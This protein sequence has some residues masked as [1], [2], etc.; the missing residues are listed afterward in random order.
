M[1]GMLLGQ[2]RITEKIGAGAQP[3]N[4]VTICHIGA[5]EVK[6]GDDIHIG[7]VSRQGGPMEM[8]TEGFGQNGPPLPASGYVR[9]A[10]WSPRS[11]WMVSS[12]ASARRASGPRPR[13]SSYR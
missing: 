9:Y 8:L 11:R 2:Y 10:V 4:I 1:I 12:A 5:E 3:P 13:S 7:V 6:R